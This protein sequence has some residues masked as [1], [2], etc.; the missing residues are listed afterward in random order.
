MK[1]KLSAVLAVLVIAGLFFSGC[2]STE[3]TS[4]SDEPLETTKSGSDES[5]GNMESSADDSWETIK[6]KGKFIVG[7]DIE[8]PPM[9][10]EDVNGEIVGFDI[11]MAKEAAKILGV[12]VEFQPVIWDNVIM[13]LNNKNIDVIWNGLSVT[14]ER[15]EKILFTD[16]YMEDRQMIVVSKGSSIKGK[17]DLAGK[18]VGLQ[19]GS[20]SE[21]ALEK[22][23]ETMESIGEI[24]PYKSNNDA[25]M[26]L[27]NGRLDAVVV[28]EVVGRY[29]IA[30]H[31]DEYE[32]LED[33][34]GVEE[35][36]VGLR[37]GD[38][39]FAEKLNEA[40]NQLK[41]NGKAEEIS[42]KWFGENVVK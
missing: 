22:D 35:F 9:G 40:I 26:D 16:P 24:V 34:F 19:A 13:E 3:K 21:K 6:S 11:D 5:S 2:T 38:K 41:E 33:H 28:D 30:K 12:E 31:M 17:A 27:R 8:F 29:Y 39:A 10:F 32:I 20:S 36:A 42:I 25:L 15:K 23:K 37:K 18:T 14:K 4:G 1:R 7:L